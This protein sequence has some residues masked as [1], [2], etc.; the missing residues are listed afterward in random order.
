MGLSLSQVQGGQAHV[1]HPGDSHQEVL[2][3]KK[4]K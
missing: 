3:L 1:Q 4:K 2:L